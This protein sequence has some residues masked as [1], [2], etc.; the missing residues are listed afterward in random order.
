MHVQRIY[1]PDLVRDLLLTPQMRAVVV[2]DNDPDLTDLSLDNAYAIAL[3]K[4]D[5]LYGIVLGVP[6]TFNVLSVTIHI[7][8]QY[9]GDKETVPL[10]KLALAELFTESDAR[11]MVSTVPIEDANHLRHFQRVGFKREGV[12][13]ASFLRNGIMLDQ[14]YVGLIRD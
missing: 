8:P 5:T 4:D 11:K 13:K 14:Y 7:N 10:T 9:W 12:C 6:S 1:N 3:L 2:E